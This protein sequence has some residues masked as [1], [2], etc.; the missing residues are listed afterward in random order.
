MNKN[1]YYFLILILASLVT[2]CCSDRTDVPPKT[3]ELQLVNI[4]VRLSESSSGNK[5][6]IMTDIDE[7]TIDKIDIL[8]F[9]KNNENYEYAYRTKG[10]KFI[11]ES[12]KTGKFSVYLKPGNQALVIIANAEEEVINASSLINPNENIDSAL[13]KIK[14]HSTEKWD[15]ET[16]RFIPM[17]CKIEAEI[18]ENTT[19]IEAAGTYFVRMLARIDVINTASDFQLTDAYLFKP[20]NKG[21]IAYSDYNWD[22]GNIKVKKAE[23]PADAIQGSNPF[24]YA[25]SSN[26]IRTIYTFESPAVN[27]P[28]NGTAI[29]IGGYYDYPV[30]NTKKSYY[31]I[32]IPQTE[33]GFYNGDIVRNYLYKIDIRNVIEEGAADEETAYNE[34]NTKLETFVSEWNNAKT[35]AIIDGQYNLYVNRPGIII[36]PAGSTEYVDVVTDHPEGIVIA[37]TSSWIENVTGGKDGDKARKLQIRVGAYNGPSRSGNITIKAG[38]MRYVIKVVQ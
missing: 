3:D 25:S 14:V 30:N 38:N 1:L 31:R 17:Y 6:K 35:E 8:V 34:I 37:E 23:A 20:M 15:V 9:L 32:D 36:P 13:P 27:D 26:L 29:V 19:D 7:N 21:L 24:L 4:S 10:S 22:P 12:E 33:T 28:K 2:I 18:T 5:S 11:S 16:P